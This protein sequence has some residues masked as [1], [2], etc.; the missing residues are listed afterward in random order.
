MERK[1]SECTICK[2]EGEETDDSKR[3]ERTKIFDE[4]GNP[5]NIILCRKHAVELF[6]LGQK[7][8]LLTHYKILA[9]IIASDETKFLEVLEQTIKA[10]PDKIY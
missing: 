1:K 7:K 3:L 6:K 5:V 4:N 10:N 9:D 8:F 2:H